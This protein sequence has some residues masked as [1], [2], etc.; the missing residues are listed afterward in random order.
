MVKV[1]KIVLDVL[2]P[3]EPNGLAFTT[4]LA[5]RTPGSTVNLTVT[6]VDEKTET[7]V[8][9]IEGESL[10]FAVI[11]ETIAAMGC[12]VHSID[13]VNAENTGPAERD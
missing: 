5:E 12:S 6:A 4:A 1:R 10:D 3:H 13:E 7:V 9:V 8:V 11:R 2:K